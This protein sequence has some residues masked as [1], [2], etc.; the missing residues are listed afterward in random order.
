MFFW[1]LFLYI[2][3]DSDDYYVQETS[4]LKTKFDNVKGNICANVFLNVKFHA[5]HNQ[6]RNLDLGEIRWNKFHRMHG[7]VVETQKSRTACYVTEVDANIKFLAEL[8]QG[9][10]GFSCSF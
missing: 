8:L 10:I 5:E 1:V 9:S 3:Q 4:I 2:Y 6:H 7:F